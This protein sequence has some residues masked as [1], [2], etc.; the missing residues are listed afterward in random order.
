MIASVLLAAEGNAPTWLLVLGPLGG[1]GVYFGLW[2]YYRNTHRSHAFERETRIAA[3]SVT[4][5]DVKFDEITGT[6]KSRIDNGN[7]SNHHAR[8][9]RVD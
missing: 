5:T 3:Q 6:K 7:Q 8:V 9:Q 1:G 2:R 4:G